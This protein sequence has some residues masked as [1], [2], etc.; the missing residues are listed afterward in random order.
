MFKTASRFPMAMGLVLEDRDLTKIC[1]W[2]SVSSSS[3]ILVFRK[4][5]EFKL[6]GQPCVSRCTFF[7]VDVS[8]LGD[9]GVHCSRGERGSDC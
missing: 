3:K 5:A 2:Q 4:R 7:V 9:I 1:L 8:Q 6:E